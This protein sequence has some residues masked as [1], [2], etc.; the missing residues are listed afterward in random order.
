MKSLEDF[1]DINEKTMAKSLLYLSVNHTGQDDQMTRLVSN[2]FEAI[3]KADNSF[4]KK[5][6]SSDKKT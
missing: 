3:K 1:K 5:K 2:T 4:L 6:D